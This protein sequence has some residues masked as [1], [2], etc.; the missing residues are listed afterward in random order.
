MSAIPRSAQSPLPTLS[1]HVDLV[2]VG[3]IVVGIFVVGII[4]VGIF[5]AAIIVVAAAAAVAGGQ[6]PQNLGQTLAAR[7]VEHTSVSSLHPRPERLS[8]HDDAVVAGM[9]VVG[10]MVGAIVVGAMVGIIVVGAM[11]GIIVVG[12]MVGIIVVGAMVGII[13]VVG[14]MVVVAGAMVVSPRAPM[15]QSPEVQHP[16]KQ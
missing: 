5:V 7:T 11:V 13:V 2:V 3:I 9:P 10:A 15:T 1:K 6:S 16:R 12:A 4:V 8:T 14:I